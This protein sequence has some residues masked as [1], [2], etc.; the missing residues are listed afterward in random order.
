M[1]ISKWFIQILIT[2]FIIFSTACATIDTN[3]YPY[4][5]IDYAERSTQALNDP[6]FIKLDRPL[7]HD[8]A[9]RSKVLPFG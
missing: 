4:S 7:H 1:L 6:Q 8:Y 9:D 2:L 3:G 5:H